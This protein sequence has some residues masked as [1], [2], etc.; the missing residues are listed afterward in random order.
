[1]FSFQLALV[2]SS[3]HM[4]FEKVK[5]EVLGFFPIDSVPSRRYAFVLC[6]SA[7]I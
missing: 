5:R 7:L 6:F 2:F 1:M 4:V 3:G